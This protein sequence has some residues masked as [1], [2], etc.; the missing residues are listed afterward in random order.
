MIVAS[1]HNSLQWLMMV[2]GGALCYYGV[3]HHDSGGI[4]PIMYS[5]AQHIVMSLPATA[6]MVLHHIKIKIVYGESSS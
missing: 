4:C 5:G 1:A 2:Y 6:I 3:E